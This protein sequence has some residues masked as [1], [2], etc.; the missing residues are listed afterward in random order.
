MPAGDVYRNR[1]LDAGLGSGRASNM[2]AIVY[3]AL[4]VDKPISSGV[5]TEVAYGSYAR[6]A[7]ANTD[8]NWRAAAAFQK[9][10]GTTF[11]FPTPTTAGALPAAY[12]LLMDAVT[13]GNIIHFGALQTAKPLLIGVAVRF[14]TDALIVT[15]F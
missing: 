6:I 13:G 1:Y 2:P 12:F 10:N 4:S 14:L 7:V 5:F 3:V 11:A 9:R 15:A 8:A